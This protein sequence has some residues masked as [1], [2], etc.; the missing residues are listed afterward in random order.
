MGWYTFQAFV[1]KFG[2]FSHTNP[3]C[4]SL[5]HLY[6]IRRIQKV[7]VWIPWFLY[8]TNNTISISWESDLRIIIFIMQ[9]L[10]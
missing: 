4:L 3:S 8:L 5:Y 7:K 10:L 1:P 9:K 6:N 2:A